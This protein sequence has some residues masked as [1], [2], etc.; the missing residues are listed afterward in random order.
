M[1]QKIHDNLPLIKP[2]IFSLPDYVILFVFLLLLIS[3]YFKFFYIKTSKVEQ[4]QKAKKFVLKRFSLKEKL[5][6]LEKLK[7]EHK[8]KEFA[9]EATETLKLVL[10]NKYRQYFLFATGRELVEILENKKISKKHKESL[11]EF[12]GL[13]DPVKFAGQDLK[14]DLSDRIIAIIEEYK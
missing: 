12:F 2:E 1:I 11:K 7:A 6:T 8:W 3:I 4:I 9:L 5:K 13:L 14:D 10:E